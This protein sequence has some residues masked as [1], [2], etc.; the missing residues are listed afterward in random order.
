[1]AAG[2]SLAHR[3]VRRAPFAFVAGLLST[4]V[5]GVGQ[6]YA[7]RPRRGL[8]MIVL[9]LAIGLVV[10]VAWLQGPVWVLRLLVQPDVLLAFLV[11]NAFVFAFRAHCVLDAYKLAG[12]RRDPAGRTGRPGGRVIAVGLLLALTAAP[13]V[14]AGYYDFRS[15][16]LLT[17]VFAEEEPLDVELF[18]LARPAASPGFVPPA[19]D[20]VVPARVPGAAAEAPADPGKGAEE[21]PWAHDSGRLNV[22][23]V[24]GDAGPGRS[25]L[26]TDTMI[27]V[28]IDPRTSHA[29]V[30]SIPR[31]LQQVPM[32][33]GAA[34]DLETFPNILNA[35]WGYAETHPELYPESTTPGPTTLKAAIGNLLGLEIDYYAAVDLRGFVEVVDALGGVTV[36][37]QSYV[38]DAGVSSAFEGEEWTP[39]ELS[40]GRHELDGRHALAYVRTRW[41]TSD[42]DRMQRQRCLIGALADQASLTKLFKAFP[43][44]ASTMKSYVQTDVPIKAL[45]DLI[46]LAVSLDTKHM[47]AVSFVPPRFSGYADVDAMRAAVADALG[48]DPQLADETGLV[49]LRSGCA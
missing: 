43:R 16:D 44:L 2:S 39:I 42:Y 36:N 12:R 26:R 1:V 49:T 46:A 4:L 24:G 18:A 19:P 34:T 23:L 29:A 28:S 5:P 21:A 7:G 8:V 22:L 45:P 17:S 9:A 25:G 33:P 40:P 48:K 3:R 38:Y 10:A 32:P 31:N 47:V 20:P 13:H 6:V 11:A 14:A 41:A 15:Y 37:V 30:F 27:V 35:L